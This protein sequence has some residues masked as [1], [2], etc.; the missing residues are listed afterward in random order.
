MQSKRAPCL[1][2]HPAAFAGPIAITRPQNLRP[3][4]ARFSHTTLH[5][6][7]IAPPR[8]RPTTTHHPPSLT[9]THMRRA[10]TSLLLSAIAAHVHGQ[11]DDT[12]LARHTDPGGDVAF[13]Q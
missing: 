5:P 1:R 4:G 7:F 11:C 9:E 2:A 3:T 13:D 12:E 10:L 8:T 6:A